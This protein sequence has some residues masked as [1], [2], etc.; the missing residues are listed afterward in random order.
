MIH[1]HRIQCSDWSL[2]SLLLV[3]VLLVACSNNSGNAVTA[4]PSAPPVNGFGIAAN[5]VHSLVALP[6]HVLLLATHYGT[7]RSPNDGQTWQRVSDGPNQ[8]MQGLMNYSLTVSPLNMQ[9]VYV[10]TQPALPSATGTLGLYTS[11]DNGNTWKLAIPSSSITSS[12]I[13]T[14]AAGNDTPDEVYIYL[15]ELGPLGLKRSL[16]DGQHFTSAGQLP[17]GVI[18]GILAIP[19]MPGRLLVYGS[20]GMALSTNGGIS[21]SV[22]S[23]IQGGVSDVTTPSP[24]S[25]I[26]AS[27]DA[28]IYVS[29]N[30]GQSFT[31]VNNQASYGSLTVSPTNTQVVYG[32][33]GTGVYRSVDGGHTWKALPPIKGNLGYLAADPDNASV[34]YLSLSYP[35]EVYRFD[36]STG[37]WTSLTPKA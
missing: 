17:F 15:V 8:L 35:T 30:E 19:N 37:V 5:H 28:G 27:G 33:T 10:L 12:N 20:N 3:T 18:S 14:A 29:T 2:L 25:P 32:L 6:N 34:V 4:A 1:I 11:A 24:H 26:Y 36:S 31:L 13:F 21:W 16:D 22:I 7:F 9:R 23:G